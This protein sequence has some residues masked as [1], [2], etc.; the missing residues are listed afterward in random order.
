MLGFETTPL[1]VEVAFDGGRITS[2]GGLLWLA[3]TDEELGVCEAFSECVPEWRGASVSHSLLAL[4]RQRVYQI[5]CGYEDQNDSDTLTLRKDPLLKLVVGLLP[6]SGRDL[7]SQPTIWRL[8][9]VPSARDRARLARALGEVYV[10]ERGA[11]AACPRR[12]CSTWTL[13]T[14]PPTPSR[15][16]APTTAT[17]ASVCTIPCS[18]STA[19]PTS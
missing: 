13:P 17:I 4:V 10:R 15:K 5:A 18:S 16:A 19:R 1:E 6:E 2:D 14:I 11:K 9:N 3:K 7:A 8:E 12:Y